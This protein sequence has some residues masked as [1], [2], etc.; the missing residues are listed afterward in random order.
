[1]ENPKIPSS[2]EK[3]INLLIAT[4]DQGPQVNKTLHVLKILSIA[5]K[6]LTEGWAVADYENSIDCRLQA[7]ER[8]ISRYLQFTYKEQMGE[9]SHLYRLVEINCHFS[10]WPT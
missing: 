5:T 7:A 4:Q 1:L 6:S 8:V 2:A 3:W 10:V 9:S